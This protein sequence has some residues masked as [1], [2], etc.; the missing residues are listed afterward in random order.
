VTVRVPYNNEESITRD[1]QKLN[2]NNTLRNK[3]P[4]YMESHKMQNTETAMN[5]MPTTN[6]TLSAKRNRTLTGLHFEIRS[7][8][9]LI[10]GKKETHQLD[11]ESKSY[12]LSQYVQG[13]S[14]RDTMCTGLWGVYRK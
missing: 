8:L 3:N 11:M 12:L 6:M 2:E 10:M 7:F 14:S 13:Q 4:K 1:Y 5:P 9:Y